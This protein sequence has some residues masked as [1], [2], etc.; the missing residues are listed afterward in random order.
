MI[1][2]EGASRLQERAGREIAYV[3]AKWTPVRRQE[4]APVN[5]FWLPGSRKL[6]DL[7]APAGEH[8]EATLRFDRAQFPGPLVPRL[9]HCDIR[10]EA[11]CA[12]P[13]K[14]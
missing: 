6:P 9:R 2:E 13:L 8:V 5:N 10:N 14:G 3:P 1:G 11:L 4:H 7:F 12:Q